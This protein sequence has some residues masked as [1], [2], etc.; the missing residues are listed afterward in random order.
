MAKLATFYI[1]HNVKGIA[2]WSHAKVVDALQH[3]FPSGFTAWEATGAWQGGMEATT[4]CQV[5]GLDAKAAKAL[6]KLLAFAFRQ[7]KVLCTIQEVTE[8]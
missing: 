3:A 6:Q 2:T 7:E 1:G 4:V 8:L 5:L